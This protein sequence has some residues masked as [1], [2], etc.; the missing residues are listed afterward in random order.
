MS[1]RHS[2]C[3]YTWLDEPWL[4]APWNSTFRFTYR[5]VAETHDICKGGLV[6]SGEF[7]VTRNVRVDATGGVHPLPG[8]RAGNPRDTRE[9][10]LGPKGFDAVS[11]QELDSDS[12]G[13]ANKTSA[14]LHEHTRRQLDE[15]KRKL[16]R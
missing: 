3:I 1:K 4:P 10:D 15:A 16:V 8:D 9:I 5:F 14:T 2:P 12:W 7:T 11:D 13:P 6:E